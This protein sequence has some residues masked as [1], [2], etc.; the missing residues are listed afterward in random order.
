M[1]VIAAGESPC[2]DRN[3][4]TVGLKFFLRTSITDILLKFSKLKNTYFAESYVHYVFSKVK[5]MPLFTF[6]LLL[7]S[8]F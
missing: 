2:E 6:G 3:F 5:K 7:V 8:L 4:D 1:L